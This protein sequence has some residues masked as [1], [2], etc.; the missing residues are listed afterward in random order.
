MIDVFIIA[1]IVGGGA[2]M[3]VTGFGCGKTVAWI[4]KIV[5]VA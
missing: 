4:R 3:W 5:S 2:L 1:K